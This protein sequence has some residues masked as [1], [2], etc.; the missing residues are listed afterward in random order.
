MSAAADVDCGA[1]PAVTNERVNGEVEVKANA[2]SRILGALGFGAEYEKSRE[3]IFSKY[4]D[5]SAARADQY[6][7]FL[8]CNI[9][10]RSTTMTDQE[11]FEKIET[12][13]KMKS[14]MP[15]A[16][17]TR[18]GPETGPSTKPPLTPDARQKIIK[19]KIGP[20]EAT[21]HEQEAYRL[22][23]RDMPVSLDWSGKSPGSGSVCGNKDDA[24]CRAIMTRLDTDNYSYSSLSE[25]CVSADGT[26]YVRFSRTKV[27]DC[28]IC[29]NAGVCSPLALR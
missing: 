21:I 6:L 29:N 7:Y 19:C 1:P 8:V 25:F 11:K 28:T 5:A 24:S 17:T 14:V 15:R 3:D 4:D 13:L 2:I 16:S 10:L 18:P 27:G 26:V 22:L 12:L 20:D 23:T 9:V